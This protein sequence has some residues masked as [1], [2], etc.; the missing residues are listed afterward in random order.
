MQNNERENEN[1]Y[2]AIIN[3]TGINTKH[4]PRASNINVLTYIELVKLLTQGLLI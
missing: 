2:K 1:E 4:N 3:K